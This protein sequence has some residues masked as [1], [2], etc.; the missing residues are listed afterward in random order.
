[1]MNRKRPL[2]LLL[3]AALAVPSLAPAALADEIV[4]YVPLPVVNGDFESSPTA[5]TGWRVV[6]SPTSAGV[7]ATIAQDK[8]YSGAN[9]LKIVDDN[10]T[11]QIGVYSA[12]VPVQ[13]GETYRLTAKVYVAAKSVRGYLRFKGGTNAPVLGSETQLVSI[14]S[15]NNGWQTMTIEGTAP[16]GT[17]YADFYFYMGGSGT[18]TSAYID[19]VKLDH[20]QV[21]VENPLELVYDEPVE[22]GD[23]VKI[24]LSQSA[25]FGV[26][27]DGRAEQY[28][29]TVGTP[30]AFHTVDALTGELLFSQRLSGSD[31][32][33]GLTKAPDGNVYFSTNGELY[34]YSPGERRIEALGQNP[35]NKQVFDLKASADGK[36]YGATY[37]S[38]NLGRV[39]EYDIASGVFRDLGVMKEGQQY[40]RGLGVTDDYVYVGIG[41][42]AHLMRYDRRSGEVTEIDIPGISG[43]SGTLSEVDVY[44]GKL[45]VYS[46]LKLNVLDEATHAYIR[47]IDFQ[48]KV[49]P[50]S[51]YDP[52]LVYYKQNGDLYA[53][54][55]ASDT[56]AKVEGI[57]ELPDDTAV[58]SHAWLTPSSGAFAGKTV[59]AGMAAFGETFLYDPTTNAYEEHLAQVP[60][61]PAAANALEGQGDYLFIGG[62]QRGMSIYDTASGRFIYNNQAF[63][64]P[65][66]IGFLDG[67]VYF[68]T[69]SGARM[70]RLDMSKPL[71]YSE[72]GWANPGLAADLEADQDRPFTMTSGDGQLF[73]G[74][75]PTYGRLGGALTVLREIADGDGDRPRIE[76]ETYQGL[77]PNQSL[78]GLAYA[79]GK[80]YG[81]TSR[82]GGLGVDPTEPE[83]KMFVFDVASRQLSVQ[84]FTPR[85]PGLEGPI[86]LIGELAIGP[87]GLLW[88]IADG[89]VYKADGTV[90]AY[91]AALFA[92]NPETLDVVKSKIVTRSPFN[93]SKYRPYYLRFGPD[94]LLYT[95]IGRSLFAVDPAD[96]RTKQMINGTVN[97][98][99]LGSDGSIYYMNGSKLFKIPVKIDSA[100]IALSSSG[101]LYVGEEANAS[102]AV[103]LANGRQASL[104][105]AAVQYVSSDPN[106]VAAT[107]QGIAAAAAGEASVHAVVTLDGRTVVTAPVRVRVMPNRFGDLRFNPGG[108]TDGALYADAPAGESV[109]IEVHGGGALLASETVT[110]ATYG[111]AENG[112]AEYRFSFKPKDIPQDARQVQFKAYL[113]GE[114]YSLSPWIVRTPP[115]RSEMTE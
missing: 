73:I 39:F 27:P 92:M 50:P 106:V 110:G 57:P 64:Q 105:G 10:A 36:L 55:L 35:S 61:S 63:H 102:V 43:Q 54:N 107:A 12:N 3:S 6:A 94:G 28:V 104:G 103:N 33:W 30:V 46:G 18:G 66:G 20:K 85:I 53:Y 69:Y 87:D 83:A 5:P 22:I 24:A 96:L 77:V 37:S 15:S 41:T 59:L 21:T 25:A 76:F 97:L 114:L 74:T 65:E 47:T 51:P 26:G 90:D 70:Y 32:I 68:G 86:N 56:V 23:A 48:T 82:A 89:A 72:L 62:Y 79:N 14:L 31:T 17:V 49:S 16:A 1:M 81:G 19:D 29:T 40:A 60:P 4:E 71:E 113:D 52:N 13:P 2:A 38:T 111:L 8:S 108:K 95:N 67:K 9:S 75:F 99:T 44:G 115:G 11:N 91:D 42:T 101:P 88:G 78:F 98:M 7:S 93:T 34:R 100:D 58:K 80:V 109:T 45:L 112:Q 84:P